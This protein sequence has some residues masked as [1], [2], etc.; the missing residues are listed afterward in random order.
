MR[1]ASQ[2]IKVETENFDIQSIALK[3]QQESLLVDQPWTTRP[4]D[5]N[6]QI[7]L[8]VFNLLSGAFSG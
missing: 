1:F 7:Q 2:F 4:F 3:K 5:V 8:P 6:S